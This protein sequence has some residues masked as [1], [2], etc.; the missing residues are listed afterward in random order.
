MT[1]D[2]TLIKKIIDMLKTSKVDSSFEEGKINYNGNS[3]QLP[4]SASTT[5]GKRTTNLK[6]R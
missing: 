3:F 4:T 1:N 5:G 6:Y 2:E